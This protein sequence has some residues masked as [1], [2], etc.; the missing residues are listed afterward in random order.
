MCKR[1][2]QQNIYFLNIY[3]NTKHYTRVIVVVVWTQVTLAKNYFYFAGPLAPSAGPLAPLFFSVPT[4]PK[5]AS[6]KFALLR[7]WE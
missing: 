2:Y 7:A 4:D 1:V 6:A 5:E 3:I